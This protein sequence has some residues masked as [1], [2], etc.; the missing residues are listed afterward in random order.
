MTPVEADDFER[1]LLA[2]HE[3]QRQMAIERRR[4]E[5]MLDDAAL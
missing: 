1:R 3:A 2:H 4:I 5:Q